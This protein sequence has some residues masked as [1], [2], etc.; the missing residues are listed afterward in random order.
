MRAWARRWGPAVLVMS[1]IFVASAIPGGAIP[2]FSI[3]D[4]MVKKG[5][6]MIGYALLA[7]AFFRALRGDRG[8]SFRKA[9]AAV[10]LAAIYASSD[11]LHQALTPGRSPSP[12]D[13]MIDIG[14]AIIGV[15]I[16][17][18]LWKKREGACRPDRG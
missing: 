16:C 17:G 7:G 13:V 8:F 4:V 18:A 14:G 9:I 12:Y 15:S 1:L 11:E 10:C 5:G 2:S 6:H 3:W